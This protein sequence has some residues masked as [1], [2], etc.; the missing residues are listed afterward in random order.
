[1]RLLSCAAIRYRVSLSDPRYRVSVKRET[2]GAAGA[3]IDTQ[4]RVGDVLDVSAPR[5]GFTLRSGDDPVI[6]LSAGVGATPVLAML[7]ALAAE[8]SAREVWWD[9]PARATAA[10][11]RLPQRRESSLK[12]CPAAVAT[13]ATA[14]LVP[15]TGRLSISMLPDA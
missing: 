2:H 1:M 7:H 9:L 8:A 10:I 13:S 3:Y 11:I 15:R 5:G 14:H 12:L 6:L 4:V